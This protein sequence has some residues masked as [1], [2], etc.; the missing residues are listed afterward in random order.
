MAKVSRPT[1]APGYS[2][3]SSQRGAT[4]A[5]R[6]WALPSCAPCWRRMAAPSAWRTPRRALLSKLRCRSPTAHCCD[7]H[8][9]HRPV[10]DNHC[11]RT[12]AAPL[13][14]R[15]RNTRFNREIWRLDSLGR[16]GVLPG[17]DRTPAVFKMACR[18]DFRRDRRWRRAVPAFSHTLAGR[19]SPDACRRA[20][21]RQDFF[22]VEYPR[23]CRRNSAGRGTRPL[24]RIDAGEANASLAELKTL[25]AV[26]FLLYSPLQ[27]LARALH[28]S[29]DPIPF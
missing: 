29:T 11:S 6:A 1:I 20:V 7:D 16:D 23:L 17:G 28:R 21:A 18:R 14:A 2:T 15:P 3:A 12:C 13:R 4:A 8:C 19:V 22:G 24:G 27:L 25:E 9:S 5:A 10:G 26:Q